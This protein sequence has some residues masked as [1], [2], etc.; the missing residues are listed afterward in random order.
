[1]GFDWKGLFIERT[2]EE[3]AALEARKTQE[4]KQQAAAPTSTEKPAAP[5]Y[6]GSVTPSEGTL[7]EIKEVYQL[8]F[9]GLNTNGYDFFE[10]YKAV[11][12]VGSQNPSAYQMAFAMAQGID[13]SVSKTSLQAK[14]DYYI[15]ELEKVHGQYAAKGTA[16][17]AEVN[18]QISSENKALLTEKQQIEAQLAALTDRLQKVTTSLEQM[19]GKY[20]QILDDLEQKLSANT[21]AKNQLIQDIQQVKQGISQNIQ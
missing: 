17:K 11:A 15:A 13:K 8:G 21:E 19:D 16:K 2:A 4:A 20:A 7:A 6:T 18:N 12:A 9:E 14:A 3:I 5:V 1:M 10:F